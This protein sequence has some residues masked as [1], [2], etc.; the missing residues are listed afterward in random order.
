M[1]INLQDP[2]IIF[3]ALAHWALRQ[4]YITEETV[5]TIIRLGSRKERRYWNRF[6]RDLCGMIADPKE[7]GG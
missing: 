1:P 4:G 7:R 6:L 2:E 3:W 5:Q